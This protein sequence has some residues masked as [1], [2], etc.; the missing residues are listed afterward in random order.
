VYIVRLGDG[1]LIRYLEPGAAGSA[2]M[3]DGSAGLKEEAGAIVES[4]QLLGE[5][6][7]PFGARQAT[8]T[9]SAFIGDDRGRLWK[10]HMA[11]SDVTQWCLELYFDTLLAWDYPYDDCVNATCTPSS[12]CYHIDCCTGSASD[13]PCAG[14]AN[15][16]R[17]MDAPRITLLGAPTIAQNKQGKNVLVFGV[18]SMDSLATWSRSR[19]F[20]ITEGGDSE[21]VDTDTDDT[22]PGITRTSPSVNWWIGDAIPS[23]NPPDGGADWTTWHTGLRTKM[24]GK[25]VNHTYTGAKGEDFF[26]VGEKLV[27]RPV[28]FNEVAYFTTFLPVSDPSVSDACNSGG[29]RIWGVDYEE[30]KGENNVIEATYNTDDFGKLGVGA[31][32]AMFVETPYHGAL[33]SG[34]KVVA[35]PRCTTG[36]DYDVYELTAQKANPTYQQ[37]SSQTVSA[38]A[39]TTVAQRLGTQATPL[40]RFVRFDSW[41]IVFE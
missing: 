41:S 39:I 27:G 40:S 15:A 10:I 2:D 9:S 34:V 5:P 18:G 30:R 16:P 33:L 38:S 20:S 19:I 24:S 26:N 21:V 13:K 32:A 11:G 1:K 36:L 3:C 37:G 17:N 12:T 22:D 14:D 31:N 23:S 28:V 25:Q 8:V 4:V 29:S 7:V 6:S 35:R